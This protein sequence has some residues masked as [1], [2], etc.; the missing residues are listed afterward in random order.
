MKV[1]ELAREVRQLFDYVLVDECQDTNSLQAAILLG[2]KPDGA[3]LTVVGDDAQAIY[4]FRAA[5]VRNIL[6]FPGQFVLPATVVKL[7]EN[8]RSIQPILTASNAVIGL[9]RERFT[10]N[11]RTRRLGDAKRALVT[12]ADDVDQAHFIV[13]SVLRKREAGRRSFPHT[14]TVPPHKLNT[15][16]R[17]TTTLGASPTP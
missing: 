7:E 12:V 8:Y 13:E 3:G 6:D 1:P 14:L 16:P 15:N 2:L 5:N 9:A 10:K 4:G 17:L 11:L